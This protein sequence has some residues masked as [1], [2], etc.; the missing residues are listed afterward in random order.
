MNLIRVH[1]V[2]QHAVN[3]PLCKHP[4]AADAL[5]QATFSDAFFVIIS[6]QF[7]FL[8]HISVFLIDLEQNSMDLHISIKL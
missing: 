5:R 6:I 8:F 2:R 7:V 4:D 3:S 1:T